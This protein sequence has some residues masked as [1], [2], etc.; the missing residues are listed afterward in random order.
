MGLFPG[1]QN[2]VALVAIVNKVTV[3]GKLFYVGIG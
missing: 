2:L 1:M 3:E